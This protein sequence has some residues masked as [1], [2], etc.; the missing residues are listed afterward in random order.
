MKVLRRIFLLCYEF[1][2]L[3]VFPYFLHHS[4][5][6][7][8]GRNI[9]HSY[10]RKIDVNF[11]VTMTVIFVIVVDFNALNQRINNMQR[12]VALFFST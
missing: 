6:F 12:Y 5:D 4:K 11:D 8:L 9:N 2:V 1:E 3:R 7:F 10:C